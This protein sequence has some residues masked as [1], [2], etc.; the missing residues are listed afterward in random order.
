MPS[1][2]FSEDT[3]LRI[4]TTA[5]F[6]LPCG[7]R[8]SS[9]WTELGSSF[10]PPGTVAQPSSGPFEMEV[11]EGNWRPLEI[12]IYGRHLQP[13]VGGRVNKWNWV[14][15]PPPGPLP[16]KGGMWHKGLAKG[17]YGRLTSTGIVSCVEI[18]VPTRWILERAGNVPCRS[19]DMT[20][21]LYFMFENCGLQDSQF[22]S[23]IL[24]FRPRPS[25]P[26][27]LHS[28]NPPLSV[29]SIAFQ[30]N[31][32]RPRRW[33]SRAQRLSKSLGRPETTP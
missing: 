28:S 8:S 21:A 13:F 33:D 17:A 6:M 14:P 12:S 11:G 27:R 23:W 5:M 22:E 20:N 4:L 31:F 7:A 1:S 32:H 30:A 3:T 29:C 19:E 2:S 25:A 9:I 10:W 24:Q 15:D 18:L 16:P 26:V